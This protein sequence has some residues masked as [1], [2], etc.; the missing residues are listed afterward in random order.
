MKDLKDFI[1]EQLT[2]PED[3]KA[4][5]IIKPGFT[6]YQDEIYDYITNK[7]FIINE[8]TDPIRLS[9]KQITDLYGC[10]SK[11]EWYGD[12]CKY[13]GSGDVCAANW[14]FN[15][16]KNPGVNT[17]SLMKDIKHHFRDKYG[18]D[19]MRN[20]MHSSDSLEHVQKEG[21]IFF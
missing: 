17:I 8:K 6:Q 10:H 18:K 11:E 2:N 3:I 16:D 21:K 4:F 15:Y 19:D 7:G 14:K 12:L 13:M 20:C 9:N 1:I 5:T